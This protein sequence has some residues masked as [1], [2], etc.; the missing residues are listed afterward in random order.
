MKRVRRAA[1]AVLLAA[2]LGLLPA[3]ALAS[4]ATLDALLAGLQKSF[5]ERNLDAFASAFAPEIRDRER[6]NAAA[7]MNQAGMTSL[8]LRRTGAGTRSAKGSPA[9]SSRCSMR[10]TPGP[11]SPTG[12]SSS[13]ATATA[14]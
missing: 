4:P 13:S 12:A 3:A 8:L 5:A 2:A 14:G 1:E 11:C 10:T 9:S 7:F 6:R